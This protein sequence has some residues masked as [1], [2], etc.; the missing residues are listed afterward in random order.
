MIVNASKHRAPILSVATALTLSLGAFTAIG[1]AVSD[2][3]PEAVAQ[4]E[5]LPADELAAQVL[6]QECR[7]AAR[8]P[9]ALCATP[10]T[11]ADQSAY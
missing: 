1:L 7:L 4:V 8:G 10:T 9:S 3:D 5:P 11:L 6:A 2:V